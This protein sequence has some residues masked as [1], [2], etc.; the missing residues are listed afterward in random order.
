MKKIM[1]KKKKLKKKMKM[2][3][4]LIKKKKSK[5]KMKMKMKK[6]MLNK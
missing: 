3:K 6:I 1:I 5:K 2:K 4:I